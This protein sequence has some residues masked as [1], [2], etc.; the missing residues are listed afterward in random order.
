MAGKSFLNCCHSR[1]AEGGYCYECGYK[2]TMSKTEYLQ[3][4]RDRVAA[5]DPVVQEIRKLEKLLGIEP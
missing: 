2:R 3:R 5:F 1:T 4:L